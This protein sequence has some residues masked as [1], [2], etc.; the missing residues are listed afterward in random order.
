M[1][2]YNVTLLRDD[3]VKSNFAYTSLHKAQGKFLE[4]AG[5]HGMTSDNFQEDEMQIFV[6][7]GIYEIGDIFILMS[8]A[9]LEED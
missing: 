1:Q 4:L 9:I 7:N 6:D 8:H 3:V 2:I 5:R